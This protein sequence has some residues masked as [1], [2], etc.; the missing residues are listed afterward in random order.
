MKVGDI[1][2]FKKLDAYPRLPDPGSKPTFRVDRM[3]WQASEGKV[4]VAVML[5]VESLDGHD[6]IDT[7]AVI[8]ALVK[9]A[10]R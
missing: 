8:A 5:G 3:K 9:E 2:R 4:Y 6:A 10:A 1:V 7:D